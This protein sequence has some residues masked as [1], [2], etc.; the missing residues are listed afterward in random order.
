MK[1]MIAAMILALV[2]ITTS[3]T[4][5]TATP[6]P[7]APRADKTLKQIRKELVTLPF[8]SVFD[9]LAFKYEDGTVTLYGQVSRP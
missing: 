8:Y 3:V 9:N 6:R 5:L 4:P 7:E 2:A 1:K